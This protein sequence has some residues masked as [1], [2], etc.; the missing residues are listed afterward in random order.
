MLIHPWQI[1]RLKTNIVGGQQLLFQLFTL[2]NRSDSPIWQGTFKNTCSQ[3]RIS[4]QNLHPQHTCSEC[5]YFRC[6][7]I[8]FQGESGVP[9]TCSWQSQGCIKRSVAVSRMRGA[10]SPLHSTGEA[11]PGELCPVLGCSVHAHTPE[12]GGEDNEG[13]GTSLLWGK[14]KRAGT[15]LA[16]EEKAQGVPTVYRNTWG[17]EARGLSQALFT[18]AQGQDQR[19]WAQHEA[20]ER[21]CLNI[22]KHFFTVRVTMQWHTP[23]RRLVKSVSLGTFKMALL[24]HTTFWG[25]FS[26]N[27]SYAV[28]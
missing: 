26:L 6:F 16:G 11:P 20:Q 19:Q 27:S 8:S 3:T 12:Q 2:Q 10:P 17:E 24:E 13:S 22:G 4:F 14:T 25:A 9:A 18:G 28:F 1:A 7:F 15:V 21:L 23:S 5:V